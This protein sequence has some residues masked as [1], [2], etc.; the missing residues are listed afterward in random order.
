MELLKTH[1]EAFD[2]P[3]Q[4][5]VLTWNIHKGIGGTDRKYQLNRIIEVLQRINADIILLQEVD[6][7]VQRTGFDKQNELIAESLNY[8][9]HF[10]P[11]HYVKGIQDPDQ[12]NIFRNIL[13]N[14]KISELF[15]NW[16]NT[17]G[18]LI[19]TKFNFSD[20]HIIDLTLPF[21]KNR[22]LVLAEIHFKH[23]KLLIGSVHLGLLGLERKK[24]IK[25]IK[26]YL[27]QSHFNNHIKI[28][29]GDFNDFSQNIAE[30][31]Y[32]FLQ[33]GA[34]KSFPAI[35]P[36]FYLDE[37][38]YYNPFQENKCLPSLVSLEQFKCDLLL[39]NASDHLPVVVDFKLM[40]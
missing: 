27:S 4:L 32:P 28:I 18:N 31:F 9:S 24:Q 35:K 7:Q 26:K 10:H 6:H 11:I 38:Y 17:Y 15:L 30:D 39:K 23:L 1:T 8:H 12:K 14:Q 2:L 3:N 34:K 29:G 33:S 37:I 19:L 22:G 16:E 40:Q 20:T 25:T 36:F 13:K 21:K 5:R